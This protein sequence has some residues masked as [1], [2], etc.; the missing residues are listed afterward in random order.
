MTI[1]KLKYFKKIIKPTEKELELHKK[2]LKK[3]IKKNDFN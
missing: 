3:E 2:F 1:Q